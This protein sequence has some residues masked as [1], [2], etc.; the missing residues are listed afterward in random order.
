MYFVLNKGINPALIGK[1]NDLGVTAALL[2]ND[3]IVLFVQ[4]DLAVF[5]ALWLLHCHLPI[6]EFVIFKNLT[7]FRVCLVK[8]K[9][10]VQNLFA[11][12]SIDFAVFLTKVLAQR[13][14]H[15]GCIDQLH[16]TFTLS[17]LFVGKH[18]EIGAN[19]GI[20]EHLLRQRHDSFQQILLD[21]ILT[22]IGRPLPCLAG[23]Q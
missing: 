15:G 22:Q 11:Q 18:P 8:C 20:V 21:D 12:C 14:F 17:T 23:K 4:Q 6:T 16:L 13:S 10:Q 5:I 9:I 7:V 19:A 3:R 2:V 1:G